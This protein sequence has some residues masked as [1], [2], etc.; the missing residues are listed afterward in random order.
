[1]LGRAGDTLPFMQQRRS[2]RG[3]EN[4][5]PRRERSGVRIRVIDCFELPDSRSRLPSKRSKGRFGGKTTGE[6]CRAA[7]DRRCTRRIENRIGKVVERAAVVGTNVHV[8]SAGR[9]EVQVEVR[10]PGVGDVVKNSRS[11]DG[12]RA[13][14]HNE[15]A[16]YARCNAVRNGLWNINGFEDAQLLSHGTC[17]EVRRNLAIGIRSVNRAVAVAIHAV[18]TQALEPRARAWGARAVVAQFHVATCGAS[19]AVVGIAIVALVSAIDHTIA[20]GENAHAWRACAQI[21]G[22]DRAKVGATVTGIHIAVVARFGARN[23]AVAAIE[24]AYARRARAGPALFE[25]TS[26]CT[27]VARIGISVVAGFG[28]FFDSVSARGINGN[29][30]LVR[31]NGRIVAVFFDL[32]VIRPRRH[33]HRCGI[34]RRIN[35]RT[36]THTAVVVRRHHRRAIRIAQRH[37]GIHACC[38][39]V[40][41]RGKRLQLNVRIGRQREGEEVL[42]V[43]WGNPPAEQ[44]WQCEGPRCLP[45]NVVGLDFRI[46]F[47][48]TTGA[49][50]I[51]GH[52]ISVIAGLRTFLHAIS[53]K[54]IVGD[55]ELVCRDGAQRREMPN[56]NE[57]RSRGHVL[58]CR[59]RGPRR[60]DER[61]GGQT[62]II[63]AHQNGGAIGAAQVNDRVVARRAL[64]NRRC[65]CLDLEICVRGNGQLDIV[66]IAGG[67]DAPI[68]DKRR[69]KR[70]TRC[71][72][73]TVRF[74]LDGVTNAG[75]ARA[76]I[77]HFNSAR[78]IASV[79]VER[80][81]VVAFLEADDFPI[82]TDGRTSAWLGHDIAIESS[83]DGARCAAS[84]AAETIA[85]I[86]CFGGQD[87]AIAA[88][89]RTDAGAARAPITHFDGA[90]GRTSVA[91]RSVAVIA[92]FAHDH[93]AIIA[94]GRAYRGHHPITVE[95]GFRR[96]CRAATVAIRRIAVVTRFGTRDSAVTTPRIDA[97]GTR[98]N[99]AR[100]IRIDAASFAQ[101]ATRTRTATVHVRFHAVFDR[102]RAC[103]GLTNHAGAY[104]AHAVARCATSTTV[105]TG[106]ACSAAA[107]DARFQAVL[108]RVGTSS[109]LTNAIVANL[110]RTIRTHGAN[111]AI[112]TRTACWAAAI[113]V[114]FVRVL[115]AIGTRRKTNRSRTSTTN[116]IT[117]L[118]ASKTRTARRA[119]SAAAID[120]G[121]GAILHRV[122]AGCRL[123]NV[124]RANLV[125][126]IGRHLARLAVGASGA[127]HPATVD[128]CFCAVFHGVDARGWHARIHRAYAART[129]RRRRTFHA[130]TH[131]VAIRAA[132]GSARCTSPLRCVHRRAVYTQVGRA[133]FLVVENVRV[134][135][136]GCHHAHAVANLAQTITRHRVA[137]HGSSWSIRK[138]TYARDARSR[139][140]NRVRA[141]A[142]IR[143]GTLGTRS[144]RSTSSAGVFRDLRTIHT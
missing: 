106:R 72:A 84:I 138:T 103:C 29:Q 76:T 23:R 65:P 90:R 97:N 4:H 85:V 52:C 109:S 141:H 15:V 71:I 12:P 27:T 6:W 87:D 120:I 122:R 136:L 43:A 67:I 64:T 53:T 121:L 113:D 114:R 117:V 18:I 8:R 102:I 75:F 119:C 73:G 24:G 125:R 77:T 140:T 143:F 63:V 112:N 132:V 83:F 126:T 17:G 25:A 41:A 94:D 111:I 26:V 74:E 14:T 133:F 44:H 2:G 59:I 57:V 30:Q 62:A 45:A 79:A 16:R 61:A 66:F 124:A 46:R 101:I 91:V 131:A 9:N 60:I 139:S 68:E 3:A 19:V 22:L 10:V 36:G 55:L 105:S 96:A 13:L 118:A 110:A 116:T 70:T 92:R 88:Y 11:R 34:R 33:V 32:H 142:V 98:A 129:M 37:D 69:S 39:R 128:V 123:T 54:R 20:A 1:M 104:A 38:A 7:H 49:T 56:P 51:A 31:S 127:I 107:I 78:T 99:V 58:R 86:A 93:N 81:A 137:S 5:G 108:D 130:L 135:R 144:T 80:I 47:D 115:D 95:S 89:R 40:I 50:A 82:T 100:T 48:A 21:P 35:E 134:I 28:T 42:I